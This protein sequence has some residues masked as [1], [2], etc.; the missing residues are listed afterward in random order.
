MK[1][2]EKFII[3]PPI[4]VGQIATSYPAIQ[5]DLNRQVLLKIIHPQW[6]KDPELVE[7]FRREGQAIAQIHHP[8]VVEV[9]DLGWEEGIPYLVLEWVEGGTLKDRIQ[10]GPL[11]QQVI[12]NIAY[13]ILSGLDA[14]HSKGLV[15]RDIKPDNILITPEG[16]VKLADFSLVGFRKG[17]DITSHGVLV[18][19]PAYMAPEIL[20]GENATPL[21]DLFSLG[22]VLYEALTGSNPFASQNHTL[23]IESTQ[24]L[25]LPTLPHHKEVDPRLVRLIERLTQPDPQKRIPSAKEAL[26]MIASPSIKQYSPIDGPIVKPAEIPSKQG[27]GRFGVYHFMGGIFIISLFLFLMWRNLSHFNKS[28]G[29]FEKITNQPDVP[30]IPQDNPILI[31]SDSSPPSIH[32]IKPKLPEHLSTLPSKSQPFSTSFHYKTTRKQATLS[33]EVKPWAEVWCGDSL[34]GLSPIS[35]I[36]FPEGEYTLKFRHPDFPLLQQKVKVEE[37]DIEVNVDLYQETVA[38]FVVAKPWGTLYIDQDSVGI[39]P[40]EEPLYLLEG[41][42]IVR[43]V[44]P[45]YTPWEESFTLRKGEIWNVEVDLANGT[46]IAQL[47]NKS[48]Q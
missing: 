47:V 37:G 21:S 2:E 1:L 46:S 25:K 14:V 17:N 5:K 29:E 4:Y 7:R 12:L 15:H 30:I 35:S 45:R 27:K 38:L 20:R 16:R 34:L 39:L 36:P 31:P 40:R 41:K 22:I 24:Q 10:D 43:I 23:I 32:N 3:H 11:P 48:P 18:G 8:N 6:A 28:D 26:E 19:T 33:I 13:Q 42:H 44:H 9:Y